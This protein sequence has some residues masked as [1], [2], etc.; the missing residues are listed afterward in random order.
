L[1]ISQRIEPT[2]GR[3]LIARE[4]VTMQV[5]CRRV[6]RAQEHAWHLRLQSR[7]KLTWVGR[8]AEE[9]EVLEKE[10]RHQHENRTK[11]RQKQG[12]S[13]RRSRA[14]VGNQSS[15]ATGAN[16]FQS[17]VVAASVLA[18]SLSH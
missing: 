17:F 11:C 13:A 1:A 8:R 5:L 18:W 6:L 16:S 2:A 12:P 10:S 4:A 15:A 14:G 3:L 9:L 7:F